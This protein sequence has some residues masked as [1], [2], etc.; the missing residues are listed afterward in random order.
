MINCE[1]LHIDSTV[2]SNLGN[3]KNCD[4]DYY[5]YRMSR[6]SV[7]FLSKNIRLTRCLEK[8]IQSL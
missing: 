8:G 7:P 2:N 1:L 3:Q 5:T 4:S 6:K